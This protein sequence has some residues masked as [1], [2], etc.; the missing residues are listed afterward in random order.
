[1]VRKGACSESR[2]THDR[3]GAARTRVPS[4]RCKTRGH[5]V[6]AFTLQFFAFFSLD[7]QLVQHLMHALAQTVHLID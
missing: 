1:M 6:Q 7:T 3:F 4:F 2:G 5:G